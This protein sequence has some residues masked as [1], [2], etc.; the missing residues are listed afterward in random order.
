MR[1]LERLYAA[2]HVQS[3]P[4]RAAPPGDIADLPL[5]RVPWS[6]LP[7]VVQVLLVSGAEWV[8]LFE[9]LERQSAAGGGPARYG[10]LHSSGTSVA[11][12]PRALLPGSASATVGV[13]MELKEVRRLSGGRLSVVAHAISRFRVVRPT[14][15]APYPRAD[16]SLLPDDEELGLTGLRREG[17]AQPTGMLPRH[18]RAEAARAAAAAAALTWATAEAHTP[19]GDGLVDADPNDVTDPI[20]QGLV[21]PATTQASHLLPPLPPSAQAEEEEEGGRPREGSARADGLPHGSTPQLER[22]APVSVRLSIPQC[23]D[24]ATHAA[25]QA[26]SAAIHHV[27]CSLSSVEDAAGNVDVVEPD[28]HDDPLLLAL[29]HIFIPSLDGFNAPG[30][31]ESGMGVMGAPTKG[32][33]AGSVKASAAGSAAGGSE[34]APASASMPVAVTLPRTWSAAPSPFLLALEHAIWTELVLCLSLAH[35]L[36]ATG[37]HIEEH[38]ALPPQLLQLI[39]PAPRHGWPSAMPDAPDAA[40]WLQR[41][42]Y[43]PVRRAQRLS[44]LV[45]AI[46]PSLLHTAG[47]EQLPLPKP[48]STLERQ[49]LLQATSV[50]ER[51]QRA[52][53]FLCHRRQRLAAL[54]ALRH[55]DGA[56]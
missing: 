56:E 16:V 20:A 34:A 26:A 48:P 13:L 17:P 6:V 24:Q 36:T 1:A 45:G 39:P 55:T 8:H 49:A 7:G 21:I 3:Q 22:L 32:S 41:W 43:P 42:G 40:E 11:L 51:L 50:R 33:A 19:L 25:A 44:F 10:H 5:F 47:S 15:S 23:K 52:V 37:A 53:V 2:S 46:L 28:V 18:T 14:E 27:T 4:P 31:T 29:E 54:A 38:I 35:H 30:G 12:S 9:E